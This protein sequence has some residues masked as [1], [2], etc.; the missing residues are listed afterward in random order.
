MA[1]VRLSSSM[2]VVDLLMCQ[3][4]VVDL[5]REAMHIIELAMARLSIHLN[6]KVAILRIYI[7]RV[8]N[9]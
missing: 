4:N 9:A 8:E 2:G 6:D 1:R 3:R 5:S 7:G